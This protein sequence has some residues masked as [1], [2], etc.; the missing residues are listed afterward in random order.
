MPL[1]PVNPS[2][3][4]ETWAIYFVGPF[5]KQGKRTG[6]R[7]IIIVV[8]YVTKWAEVEPV[9]SC[10]KEVATKFIYENIITRFGC[11]LTLISDKGSHFINQTIQILLKEFLIDHHKSSA[12][13][14]QA[15]EAIESFNKT[16][17]KGLTKICN[18]DKDDQDEKIPTVP[19]AYRTTYKRATNQTPFKLVYG[20]EAIV[21]LHFRQ[22]TPKI[23]NILKIDTTNLRDE[24]MFQ[25]QKLEEDRVLAL[26][27]QEA[28]KQQ[29]KAWHDRNIKTKN[30][31]VGDLVLLYDSKV[32]GK[33]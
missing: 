16:L 8:E 19:W 4:F 31:A 6:V 33:P 2:L 18:I 23:A 27:H 15:N 30:I 13:H 24:R 12:Y 9:P 11:P 1:I 32:K 7:Y 20:Q 3:T 17:T 26:H 21:P 5:H 22:N 29:Q 14:P 25:L 28:Q 10:T